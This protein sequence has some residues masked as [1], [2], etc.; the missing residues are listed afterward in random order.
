[1]KHLTFA[2]KSLILGD[3]AAELVVKYAAALARAQS[4]DTV[5]LA[6]YGADGG[7]VEATLLLD[8]GAPLMIESNNSDLPEP[9]NGAVVEY[10]RARIGQL[11]TPLRA[12]PVQS[13]D[14]SMS[15][16]EE[17]FDSDSGGHAVP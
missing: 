17:H 1:M 2:D 4:A 12:M 9:E 10:M 14:D 6:A 13:D 5:T 8:Q 11:S 3:D 15:E 7:S 16:F